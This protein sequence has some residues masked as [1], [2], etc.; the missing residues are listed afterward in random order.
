ME[1]E[2]PDL[3]GRAFVIGGLPHE[4]KAVYDAS[5]AAIQDGVRPG[6]SLREA[7]QRCPEAIFLPADEQ[8]YQNAFIVVLTALEV[9][10]PAVAEDGLGCTYLDL[11]RLVLPKGGEPALAAELAQAVRSLTGIEPGVGIACNPFVARLAA[12][13]A[14][15]GGC[16]IIAPGEERA[17]LAPLPAAVLPLSSEALRRLRLLGLN[18][19]GAIANLSAQAIAAQL[20]AEGTQAHRLANGYDERPITPRSRP[21]TFSEEREFDEPLL[22]EAHAALAVTHIVDQLLPQLQ[23]EHLF[24]RRVEVDLSLASGEQESNV[25][26]LRESSQDGEVI[27]R[28]ALRVLQERCG[29]GITGIRLTL[30]DLQ[31]LKGGQLSLFAPRQGRLE[32]LAG[33]VARLKSRFGGD[34]LRKAVITDPKALIPERRFTFVE[35]K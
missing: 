35:Y 5:P 31:G 33:A 2:R 19:V 9:F 3:A 13:R 22:S 25:A 14:G 34:H 18:T 23:S 17:F 6:M 30:T 8:L 7:S 21:L 28:A 15:K 32:K 24:C 1:R 29:S 4:R 20:G 16:L 10:T 27:A 26:Y 11:Q 12:M